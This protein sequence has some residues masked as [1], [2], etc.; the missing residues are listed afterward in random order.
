M[1]RQP[2]STIRYRGRT[3]KVREELRLKGHRYWVTARLGQSG[4]RLQVYD[5]A[6]KALRVVHNLPDSPAAKQQL[7]A[8]RR[9]DRQGGAV[10]ILLDSERTGNN[11]R[12]L[13]TWVEGDSLASYLGMAREGRKPWPS[14][15][16]SV[17]LFR[18]F[19]H[20]LCQ[21]HLFTGSIH[22]DISPAN[23]ILQAQPITLMLI[24]YGS[25]WPIVQAAAQGNGDGA[26]PAYAA[27]ERLGEKSAGPLA[28]QFSA[29]VVFYE[30]LTGKLPY[31]GMGG[32]AGYAENRDTFEEAYQPPSQLAMAPQSVPKEAWKAIDALAKRA[33][34][35]DAP[36][37]FSNSREWRQAVDQ[38]WDAVRLPAHRSPLERIGSTIANW[39]ERVTK[40]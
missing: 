11:W 17:R 21:F 20:G 9:L 39:L 18:G 23:L 10:P 36:T 1:S 12:L 31:D 5:P 13:T 2:P 6:A 27:P 26:T 4:R 14:V 3:L 25:A 22:G 16:E 33:L 40:S 35:L 24:D 29:S 8:L 34:H 19:V 32:R 37:R 7:A 15:Y 30:M 38:A 28:D